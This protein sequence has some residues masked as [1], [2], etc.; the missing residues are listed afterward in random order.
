MKITTL[1]PHPIA[2]IF[3]LL[4]GEPFENLVADIR[5]HGQREPIWTHEGLILDGRNRHRACA[6]LGIDC[7]AQEYAGDDLTAF[8]VSMNLHRRHL[9]ESQRAMV[10]ARLANMPKGRP[11]LNAS[12]DAFVQPDAAALL[13]VSRASVQRARQVLENAIPEIVGMVD[14]GTVSVSDAAS[15][16]KKSPQLQQ[17]AVERA[18][19]SSDGKLLRA[20]RAVSLDAQREELAK[21]AIEMPEGPFDVIVLDPPWPYAEKIDVSGYDPQGHRA[22]NPYPEM[23]LDAIAALDLQGA[24][25]C[26]LW[27]WTTHRFMRHSFPLLDA[28]GFKDRVILTWAKDRMGLGR[29]LRSQSEFCIM[30]TR[31][32]PSVNLTTQTTVID[33]PQ[34]EHSRKPDEF[35]AMVDELCAGSK[36]DFFSRETRPGW[37]SFGDQVGRFN[38]E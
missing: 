23:S 1:T 27:L 13:N 19:Q 35:Y 8:V 2:E 20:A 16:A 25:D 6:A 14:G 12:I 38:V 4:E 24:P 22:S 29:W 17:A 36:L 18:K 3:P 34:R 9:N 5:E 28:W 26:V 11:E 31:G 30:A 33:G 37:Q 15:V 10:A 21:K 7:R 32:N